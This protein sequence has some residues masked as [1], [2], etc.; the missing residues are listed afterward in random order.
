MQLLD[1]SI[2]ILYFLIKRKSAF[3]T[4]AKPPS[5]PLS[6]RLILIFYGFRLATLILSSSAG[7]LEDSLFGFDL[8]SLA[9]VSYT[10]FLLILLTYVLMGLMYLRET[11]RRVV[12]GFECFQLLDLFFTYPVLRTMLIEGAKRTGS[13][14]LGSEMFI[15][16]VLFVV[17]V[18]LSGLIIWFLIK[19]KQAF[20][21]PSA[22]PQQT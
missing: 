10:V 9:A 22:P 12:I 21:K 4:H 15:L 1:T 19:R 18:V 13:E 6:I 2:I 5:M 7:K 11:V 16:T 14:H 8:P 17:N 3:R 20:I